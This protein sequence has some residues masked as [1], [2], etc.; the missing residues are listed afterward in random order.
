MNRIFCLDHEVGCTSGMKIGWRSNLVEDTVKISLAVE[1]N[2]ERLQYGSFYPTP[3]E[4]F[5]LCPMMKRKKNSFT[6]KS[7]LFEVKRLGSLFPKF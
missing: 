1:E 2:L 5:Q 6:L 7:L 3:L 4:V